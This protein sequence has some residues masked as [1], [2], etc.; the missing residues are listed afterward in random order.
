MHFPVEGIYEPALYF[1]IFLVGLDMGM[2]GVRNL[3][4][5]GKVGV[6]LPLITVLGA[7][8]AGIIGSVILNI[9]L[10]W[11]LAIT[12]GCGWYTLAGPL[13]A[14][15][16]AFYGTIG[17]VSNLIR[18]IMMV[19]GYP[20]GVKK[21]SGKYLVTIGGAST[22]DSTLAIVKKYG[23]FEDSLIA[24]LHGFIVTMVVIFIL[25]IILQMP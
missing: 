23:T 2:E 19:I 6:I 1:L 8:I 20:L 13:I 11:A 22:M 16:S 25:P 10:K 3:K 15:Y 5:V 24:F 9:P 7:I 12:T 14:Q 21:I 18:E 17:F 4:K